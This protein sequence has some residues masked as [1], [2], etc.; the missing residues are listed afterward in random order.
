MR[1]IEKC[2]PIG[3]EEKAKEL[4][5]MRRNNGVIRSARSLFRLN[6]LYVTNE[7][8]FQMA[9]TG[10]RLT[11]GIKISKVGAFKRVRRSG[12]W[13]R[14][15]A[16]GVM[17]TQGVKLPKPSFLGEHS[18]KIYDASDETT[19]GRNKSTWRLHYAFD[20]FGFKCEE[21]EV[22]SNK[23]GERLTRHKMGENDI[24][25]ADR[26]YCTVTGIE[27]VLSNHANFV[28]RFRSKAFNLYDSEGNR[29]ELLPL[30]RDLETR[31]HM[32][33]PCFYKLPTGQLRPLRMVAMKKDADAIA[34]TARKMARKASK[35][36]EKPVQANTAELNEYIVLATS[37][38]YTNEQILELYRA[39]WQIEQ[40]FLR[41]KSLF[42]YGDPPSKCPDTVLAWFYGKLLLAAL[43]EIILK[44]MIFPPALE[45]ILVDLVGAQFV[46]RI[47]P[48][49]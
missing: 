38:D 8:S 28:L 19:R 35:R 10:M 44:K 33:V 9:A 31:E 14:W 27:H 43:C 29:L 21:A 26:I 47:V 18:V 13:L 41:L 37:L 49:S 34:Q 16:Q 46:E 1:E 42:G 40:V 45:P 5:A 3:W 20:L 12:E 17:D 15:M 23:E 36:Q 24:V 39:R 7:G 30:L 22:T 48:Y 32:S 6:M 25:L 11:E 4:G 2:L